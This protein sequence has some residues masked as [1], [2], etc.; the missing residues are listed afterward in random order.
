[1]RKEILLPVVAVIGGGVGFG[2]RR[3]ELATAFEADT[4]LPIAGATATTA[5]ILLSVVMAVAL[6]ALS[7]GR[8]PDFGGCDVAFRAGGNTLYAMAGVLSAFLLLGA[9]VL[10]G[11]EFVRAEEPMYTYLIVG[12]MAIA[13]GFCVL[14]TVRNHFREVGKGRYS[15]ALLVPAFTYCVWLI[16]AYQVRAGDPVQLDYVYEL[17]AII[18]S[19]LGFYFHAAFAFTKGRPFWA[20]FFALLGIYFSITT[21]AD[22]HSW[23]TV[24]LY[25]FTILYL[26]TNSAIL[27]YNAA[28]PLP[29]KP[30][31]NDTEGSSDV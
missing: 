6:L 13:S 15:A 5:L 30:V 3:W 2:L 29:A 26:L 19:L 25:C 14:A 8:Y 17:F 9:G 10:A 23:S 28:R 27:L 11:L 16:A 7:R 1:M 18:A 20:V 24:L 4:G 22:Q 12:A 31:E 21:L